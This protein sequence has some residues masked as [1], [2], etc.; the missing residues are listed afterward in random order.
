MFFLTGYV[1]LDCN[2]TGLVLDIKYT[3]EV[4]FC[5]VTCGESLKQCF[6]S[7]RR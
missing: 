6:V 7:G 5:Q 2:L 4:T 1:L 3:C